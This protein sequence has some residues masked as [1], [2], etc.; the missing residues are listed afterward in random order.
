MESRFHDA[1]GHAEGAYK[2]NYYINL[3]IVG[4]GI[5]FLMSSLVMSW[6]NGI[7]LQT[8][9]F[10]GIGI[11]DFTALFLVNPQTRIQ[12]LLGDLSQIQIIYQEWWEQ[13]MLLDR[14]IWEEVAGK[15]RWMQMTAEQIAAVNEQFR[16]AAV[17][18]I[19]NIETYIGA[20]KTDKKEKGEV[21][22]ETEAGSVSKS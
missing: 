10:A 12:Q 15:P 20:G 17:D 7:N 8:V 1:M 9:S 6:R 19:K 2:T 4:I 3:I 14:S 11:V 22:K 16:I 13:L 18:S 21:R 5:L